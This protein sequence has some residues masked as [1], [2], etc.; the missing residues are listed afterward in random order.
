MF[1]F[2][3]EIIP[4]NSTRQTTIKKFVFENL[5]EAQSDKIFCWYNDRFEEIWW[6]YPSGTS[7]EPDKIARLNIKDFTWVPDTL[8]RTAA[9]YT[10]ALLQFHRLIDVGGV[11]H[12]HENGA[13]D[14]GSALTWSLTGPFQGWGTDVVRLGAVIPDSIQ[15]SNITLTVNA[16]QYPQSSDVSTSSTFTIT[17]TLERTTPMNINARYSQYTLGGSTLLQTW[18]GGA[19]LQEIQRSSRRG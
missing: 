19:W 14:D 9:E 5:N 6:H 1:G 4:S 16:K 2:N 15:L 8:D 12:R 11:I 3:A 10:N 13:N 7:N 18:R 17:P